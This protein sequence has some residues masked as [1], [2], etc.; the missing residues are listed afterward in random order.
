[1]RYLIIQAM[2]GI[3]NGTIMEF[4]MKLYLRA[5]FGVQDH[6]RNWT[7]RIMCGGGCYACP[8]RPCGFRLVWAG[9]VKAFWGPLIFS[10]IDVKLVPQRLGDLKGLFYCSFNT[11]CFE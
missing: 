10:L 9:G 11:I 3:W 1:M 4:G 5:E 2:G 7:E 6:T 8:R